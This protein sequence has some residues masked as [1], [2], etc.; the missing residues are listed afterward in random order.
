GGGGPVVP[1]HFL[2]GAGL[3][4]GG[5]PPVWH[6]PWGGGGG[7]NPRP[8]RAADHERNPKA[9]PEPRWFTGDNINLS[10]GQ[11]ETVVTPLQLASLYST[12]TNGGTAHATRIGSE[13]RRPD[14]QP[15]RRIP[16]RTTSQVPL[17]PGVTGPVMAG[18]RAAVS[19]PTGTAFAAFSGFPLN[20][21]PVGGKTGTAQ[22]P[23]RQD[24]ALFVGF[25]P[26]ESPRYV[27]AVV[28]EEAGFGSVAAAPVARRILEKAFGLPLSPVVAG[29]GSE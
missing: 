13:I 21:I 12:F 20:Q 10:V 29:A 17:N 19:D 2:V 14:G 27:V 5:A 7:V 28:M 6:R 25:A 16:P 22:A 1:A 9:F 26:V 11:G 8:R 4:G 23:P 15:V 3:W 18:F 24:T